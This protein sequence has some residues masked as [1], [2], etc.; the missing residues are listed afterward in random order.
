M[1]DPYY[2][3]YHSAM[4]LSLLGSLFIIVFAWRYRQAPG[5]LAMIALA[6][7]TFVWT[8]GYLL[9]THQA[10]LEGKS[11]CTNIGYIGNMSVPI[12][13]FI[14]SLH[15]ISGNR[16]ITG[17]KI[18][19]FCVIPVVIMV[20][21]WTN[22]SHHL[23]WYNEYLSPSGPFTVTFKTYGPFFWIALAHNYIY[24]IAGVVI[25]VR[26]LFVGTP[27]YSRQAFSLLVAVSLPLIWN[28][29]YVFNLVSLPRKDLT[30]VMFAISGIAILLGLIRFH[31]FSAVPFAHKFLIQQMRDGILVFDEQKRL[32]EANPAVLLMLGADKRIIGKRTDDLSLS[33]P[34]LETIIGAGSGVGLPLMMGGEER[35][36]EIETTAM[37]DNRETQVGY[38][39]ILHDITER[40]VSE[41]EVRQL[42]AKAQI[43]SRLSAVGELASGVAHEINNPLTSVIGYAELLSD[44]EDIP[45]DMK[46][47][48]EVIIESGRR[49]AD[50]VQRLLTFA[51]HSKAARS[52]V[53]INVIINA[54]L[55]L[56][57]YTLMTNN[58]K[59]TTQLDDELPITVAD[60][61]QLQQVFLNLII[62]AE[63]E[64]RQ[65]GGEGMLLIKT[66]KTDDVIKISF[67]DNGPGIAR[68]N[69]GKIFDP[70]F[71]TKNVGEGTGLGLSICH[72][73]VTEHEGSIWA[74]SQQ[75]KG[76]TF[77]V[78]LP[79]VTE[80]VPEKEV[81]PVTEEP[82]KATGAKILVV[83]DEPEI[84]QFLSRIL[85][86][87]GYEVDAVDNAIDAL[88][89]L[90]N[91][92]YNLI[93]VDIKMSGMSGIE[94]YKHAQKIALSLARRIIFISGDILSADTEAFLSSSR[95]PYFT[96]PFDVKQL[97]DEIRRTLERNN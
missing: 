30:P 17:W 74:E 45:E 27:L 87:E 76:A 5:A 75:G 40:K 24:I 36:Y 29:I 3:F 12:A 13:W 78:E 25:L 61:G 47:D 79:I 67:T 39:T 80:I 35:F 8:L 72:S 73:I 6:A 91:K 44:R 9:E 14:F 21:V 43:A 52:N 41:E 10:T 56:R 68:E 63:N 93:L 86:D 22:P 28:I 18:L 54:V 96:K 53:D 20:L 19:P 37:R 92:R 15:Y 46:N 70:F 57:A 64:M 31:L 88:E 48:L 71:T 69:L 33:F 23:M 83:D 55:K 2:V 85:G 1:N 97:R 60:A 65:V 82:Q 58:I 50:I 81:E 89:K 32:L 59:V 16:L 26:R 7:A 66:E 34:L 51:R 42:E 4:I 49:V 95:A 94:F 77:F 84:L 38:L 11:F 90:G 62:N